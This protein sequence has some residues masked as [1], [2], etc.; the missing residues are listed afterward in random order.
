VLYRRRGPSHTLSHGLSHRLSH[1]LPTGPPSTLSQH[2]LKP[3]LGV[4]S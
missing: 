3:A 1:D 4:R 2:V